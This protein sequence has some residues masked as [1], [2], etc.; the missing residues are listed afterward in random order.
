VITLNMIKSAPVGPVAGGIMGCIMVLVL[1]VYAYRHQIHRRSHQHM[2]P[3]A[4]QGEPITPE[5]EIVGWELKKPIKNKK[6]QTKNE[7]EK[8][9]HKANQPTNKSK[10]PKPVSLVLCQCVTPRISLLP[11]L[12]KVVSRPGCLCIAALSWVQ[13][14]PL[15]PEE[16]AQKPW[17]AVLVR[18]LKLCFFSS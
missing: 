6:T 10:K 13:P 3:L 4:A 2:S 16:S 1:A 8:N 7:T 9:P 14:E 18:K 17:R 11:T 15:P 12:L 5:R